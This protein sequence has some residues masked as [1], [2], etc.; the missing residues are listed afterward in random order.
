MLEDSRL[1][2]FSEVVRQ[3]SFSRAARS[4]GVSPSAVSQSIASLETELGTRLIDRLSDPVSPT[5]AGKTLLRFTERILY[6]TESAEALFEKGSVR[7]TIHSVRVSSPEVLSA[8]FLPAGLSKILST[9]KDITFSLEGPGVD[10][11]DVTLSLVPSQQADLETR[12]SC[13]ATFG[14]VCAALPSCSVFSGTIP[15]TLAEVLGKARLAV[16]S[17]YLPLLDPLSQMR[18]S[19]SSP[20]ARSV[21]E[22]ASLDDGI[23]ALV[24]AICLSGDGSLVRIP[25]ELSALSMDIEWSLGDNADRDACAILR[26]SLGEEWGI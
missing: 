26:R 10:D 16:W 4:L 15:T 25:L 9:R 5:P 6:W 8:Y 19:L 11:A 12:L 20:S 21:M 13:I 23:L 22:A 18:V 3:G 1:R 24:P 2:M 14:A 7:T 17:D